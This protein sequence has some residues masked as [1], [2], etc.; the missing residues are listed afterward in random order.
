MEL[1]LY[2]VTCIYRTQSIFSNSM[3][4]LLI[5]L[6]V[7]TYFYTP[8]TV[9]LITRHLLALL[10]LSYT[11]IVAL[12]KHWRCFHCINPRETYFVFFVFFW[13]GERALYNAVNTAGFSGVTREHFKVA[14]LSCVW[15]SNP[16]CTGQSSVLR[17][18]AFPNATLAKF[19]PRSFWKIQLPNSLRHGCSL[20]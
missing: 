20:V 15:D 10:L 3:T 14:C 5:Q 13:C 19:K 11:E 9:I 18:H 16:E 1:N 7:Y 4:A 8:T 2:L 17:L 6:H 12:S